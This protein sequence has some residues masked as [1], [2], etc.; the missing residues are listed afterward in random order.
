MSSAPS[1]ESGVPWQPAPREQDVGE[2]QRLLLV[3]AGRR[4]LVLQRLRHEQV[5]VGRGR[6]RRAPDPRFRQ[7]VGVVTGIER[8]LVAL[9]PECVAVGIPGSVETLEVEIGR[10]VVAAVEQR[11]GVADRHHARVAADQDPLRSRRM[12]LLNV[13]AH[14]LGIVGRHGMGGEHLRHGP[15]HGRHAL[16]VL[17]LDERGERWGQRVR[18]D[19]HVL[20]G[21]TENVGVGG[22]AAE[23]GKQCERG[24]DAGGHGRERA[25]VH[26][27]APGRGRGVM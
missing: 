5:D 3:V 19:D 8:A 26:G 22:S 15:D 25:R 20:R 21:L 1:S 13:H 27:F 24:K 18:R 4:S 7:Q 2:A 6:D 23:R 14:P 17:P 10:D 12:G 9:S 16:F 11:P